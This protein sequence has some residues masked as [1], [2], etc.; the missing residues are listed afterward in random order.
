MQFR[1]P[2]F[3][4]LSEDSGKSDINRTSVLSHSSEYDRSLARKSPASHARRKILAEATQHLSFSNRPNIRSVATPLYTDRSVKSGS[5]DRRQAIPSYRFPLR[6]R[7]RPYPRFRHRSAKPEKPTAGR[8][9]LP[10]ARRFGE[11]QSDTDA[12]IERQD[13]Q[14]EPAHLQVRHDRIIVGRDFL[15]GQPLIVTRIDESS[16]YT[17]P[18]DDTEGVIDR[19]TA[20]AVHRRILHIEHVEQL[21]AVSV[22]PSRS[23]GATPYPTEISPRPN[24]A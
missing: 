13:T 7:P 6:H 12:G 19:H 20:P 11:S 8:F 10:L 2:V 1:D 18:A 21:I 4:V 23:P 17:Q 15:T 16:A 24:W 9:A 5:E 22:D 3:F 14:V